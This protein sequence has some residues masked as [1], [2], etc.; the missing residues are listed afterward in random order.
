MPWNQAN[1]AGNFIGQKLILNEVVAYSN[2]SPYLM[3]DAAE[4]TAKGMAVLDPPTQAIL[5]FALCGFA[6]FSSIAILAGG[7]G[8]V[9]PAPFGSGS[10]RLAGRGGGNAVQ[11]DECH[12]CRH[13]PDFALKVGKRAEHKMFLPQET[14]RKKLNGQGADSGRHCRFRAGRDD[15]K[16]D[17]QSDCRAGNG[18][19]LQ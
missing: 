10:L 18:R 17:G 6:N 3:K 19:V 5:S 14:I 12:D 11:P 2:L 16:S 15:W 7:F 8:V 13:F 1:I 4:L 9:A